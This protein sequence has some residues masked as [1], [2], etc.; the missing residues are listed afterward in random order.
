MKLLQFL[1]VT[2]VSDMAERMH[3]RRNNETDTEY[4]QRIEGM[5]A[6]RDNETDTE[7]QQR[8]QGIRSETV[9]NS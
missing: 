1:Y 9:R 8:L 7:Y 5:R 6:R 2:R 3:E 4:V